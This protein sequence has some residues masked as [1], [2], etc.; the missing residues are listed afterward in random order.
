MCYFFGGECLNDEFECNLLQ[1]YV[2]LLS[3]GSLYFIYDIEVQ[4]TAEH[5]G[6]S[7]GA[8]KVNN[9]SIFNSFVVQMYVLYILSIVNTGFIMSVYFRTQL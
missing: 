2:Q 6:S 1:I 8:Y 5:R 7:K 4:D 3:G 9:V